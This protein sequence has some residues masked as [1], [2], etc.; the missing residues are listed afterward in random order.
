MYSRN[1]HKS[2]PTSFAGILTILTIL[3]GLL[4]MSPHTS[5]ANTGTLNAEVTITATC[6]LTVSNSNLS[7]TIDPNST[8]QIGTYSTV[9]TICNDPSGLA[10]YA[11][12]YTNDTYG[13]NNLTQTVGNVAYD[14]PSDI[15]GSPTTSQWNMTITKVAGDYEPTIV[16]AGAQVIPQ[17]YTKV[18]YRNSMTDIGTGATGA[19]FT[20]T[21][22]AYV[23]ATQAAGTYTGKVKFLLVHPNVLAWEEDPQNPGTLIPD[24]EQPSALSCEPAEYGTFDTSVTHYLQNVSQ[25]ENQVALEQTVTAYDNRDGQAYKVKRLKMSADGC[26]SALWMSNLNLGATQLTVNLTSANTNLASGV[27]AIPY[28]TFNSWVKSSYSSSTDPELVLVPGQDAYGNKYGALYNYTA[29]S[30]GT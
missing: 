11:V 5:A 30:A 6:S 26:D 23:S 19:N 24:E 22:N 3:S 7:A 20:A 18:A 16:T 28:A 8:G 14:I 12:G 25:W 17:Q 29:A 10:V 13:N 15:D 9:K 2:I 27:S 21:F 4:L 1:I